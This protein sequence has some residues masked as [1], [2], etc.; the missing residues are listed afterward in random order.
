ML[1]IYEPRGEALEYCERAVNLYRGCDHRCSYCYA[2]NAIRLQRELFARPQPRVG[3]IEAIAKD[4]PK[5][6]GRDVLMCFT[7]DLYS[8]CN[9]EHGLAA[10]AIRELHAAGCHVVILTK[11]GRRSAADLNLLRSGD[12]YGA[13]LTFANDSQSL[14]WE[15]GAALPGERVDVLRLAKSK[16]IST[17]ASLEPVI[18]PEQSLELIRQTSG[19]VDLYKIGKWNYDARAGAI[20]WRSFAERAVAAC[21]AQGS[22]YMLKRDLAAFLPGSGG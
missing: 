22:A 4:A 12:R 5:H 11:G 15:P 20:D 16:G 18:D 2:P 8:T 17:W 6:R 14:E 19:V 1:S 10:K 9:A 7:C 3:I 13:T 21:R